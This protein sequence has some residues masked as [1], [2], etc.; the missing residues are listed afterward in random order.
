MRNQMQKY[1]NFP[2]SSLLVAICSS[3]SLS[4]FI[5]AALQSLFNNS[6]TRIIISWFVSLDCLIAWLW[7]V[8][9]CFLC[10]VIFLLYAV[11][12]RWYMV[13]NPSYLL[14]YS[15]AYFLV[16]GMGAQLNISDFQQDLFILFVPEPHLPALF[17]LCTT[18]F[19]SHLCIRWCLL[20]FFI[21]T[22]DSL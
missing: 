8:F 4:R 10:L 14:F 3:K 6:N 17:N 19:S 12:R 9:C 11:Y 16:Q 18:S 5:I 15:R 2:I 1:R 20:G 13:C 21:Y 22:K 7:V